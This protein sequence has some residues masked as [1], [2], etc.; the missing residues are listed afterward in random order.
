MTLKEIFQI[1]G[2]LASFID[3]YFKKL[4]IIKLTLATVERRPLHLFGEDF[5]TSQN[6]VNKYYE[7]HFKLL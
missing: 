4:H 1:N 5:F 7:R 3:K 2:Y 6:Q